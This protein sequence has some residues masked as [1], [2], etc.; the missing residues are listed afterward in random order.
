MGKTYKKNILK[1]NKLYLDHQTC[2]IGSFLL[3]HLTERDNAFRIRRPF[4][5]CLWVL[6]KKVWFLHVY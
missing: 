5:P 3:F 6:E 2:Y 1:I 4:N